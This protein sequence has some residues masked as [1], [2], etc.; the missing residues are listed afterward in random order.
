MS[1]TSKHPDYD[2]MTNDWRQMRDTYTGQRAVKDARHLYLPATKSMILDG[3]YT[4]QQPGLGVYDAYIRRAVFP[5]LTAIA[6]HTMVGLILKDPTQYELPARMESLLDTCTKEGEG[7][8]ALHRRV[9]LNQLVY[10]RFGLAIDTAEATPLPFFVPFVAESITNWDTF[11]WP[12]EVNNL[13]LVVTCEDVR[14]RGSEGAA[15]SY[16]WTTEQRF[17]AMELNEAGQYQTYTE[18]N[19]DFSEIVVPSYQGRTLDFIPF[20]FIGAQDLVTTPGAIP[21]LGISNAALSIYCGEADLRQ[22]LHMIGQDTLV[23][24]GVAEGSEGD[25]D[26]E[27]T[28]VG[29]NAIIELPEGGDAKYIGVNGE[30]LTEQRLVLDDDYKRAAAEGSRLL[31]NT[32]AQAESG[33]ALKVRVAAKTTTLTTVA[34]TAA[35]GLQAALRQMARWM[36]EDPMSVRI[37][38]NTDFVEDS[39]PP[40]E[41]TRLMEAKENGLPLSYETIHW[42]LRNDDYTPFTFEEELARI[43]SEQGETTELLKGSRAI[44]AEENPQPG[45]DAPNP[46]DDTEDE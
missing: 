41:V 36:G 45:N 42:Y 20:T 39:L 13:S 15:N 9:L 30:G 10:G 27:E 26:T 17:R 28:R 23:L 8:E 34:I 11:D 37:E 16:A 14:V 46:G 3:A 18:Q 7:L 5:D 25:D 19:G 43:R 33:E 44:A 31:E 21:L 32:A 6:A 24:I 12:R 1:L 4:N 38:P 2:A 22:T 29:A 35:A 40:Q